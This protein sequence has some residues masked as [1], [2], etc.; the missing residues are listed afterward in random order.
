MGC[1]GAGEEELPRWA[2]LEKQVFSRPLGHFDF[3][4]GG[5]VKWFDVRCY[6]LLNGSVGL[7]G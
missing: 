4:L 7:I 1:W 2:V 5:G 6:N 3:E